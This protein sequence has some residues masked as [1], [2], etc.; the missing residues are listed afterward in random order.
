[1][2]SLRRIPESQRS[3]YLET[4][5]ADVGSVQRDSLFY[6]NLLEDL[7]KSIGDD[8][9]SN[10]AAADRVV[11]R[12]QKLGFTSCSYSEA[13]GG[14]PAGESPRPWRKVLDWLLRLQAQVVEFFTSAGEAFQALLEQYVQGLNATPPAIAV[15]ILPPSFGVEFGTEIFLNPAMR[16]TYRTFLRSLTAEFKASFAQ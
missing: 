2:N 12:M 4:L 8:E 15:G 14:P 10:D 7:K 6:A 16:T 11:D 1:L 9:S 3:A 13:Q 5:G